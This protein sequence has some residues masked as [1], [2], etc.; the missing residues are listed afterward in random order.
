[1]KVAMAAIP[2]MVLLA[3]V[4]GTVVAVLFS[5]IAGAGLVLNPALLDA[6]GF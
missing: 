2:A 6:L 4:W 3:V 5:V 1:M